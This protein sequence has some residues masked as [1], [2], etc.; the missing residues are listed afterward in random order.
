[1]RREDVVVFWQRRACRGAFRGSNSSPRA[2]ND[3]NTPPTR[4]TRVEAFGGF[5]GGALPTFFG[6]SVWQDCRARVTSLFSGR[7]AHRPGAHSAGATLG[8]MLRA[9]ASGSTRAIAATG[10][11]ATY[12]CSAAAA[13][14]A[15]PST[16]SD[17]RGADLIAGANRRDVT[18]LDAPIAARIRPRRTRPPLSGGCTPTSPGIYRPGGEHEE[19]GKYLR[20]ALKEAQEGLKQGRSPRRRRS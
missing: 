16:S 4:V 18:P 5:R 8:A 3:A 12:L 20:R 6:S 2:S 15:G 9:L 1:M 14:E 11:V 19:A 13:T 10:A 7:R 17:D